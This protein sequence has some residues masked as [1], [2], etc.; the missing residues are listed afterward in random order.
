MIYNRQHCDGLGPTIEERRQKTHLLMLMIIT[1]FMCLELV[2]PAVPLLAELAE[3][4]LAGFARRLC[5]K[6]Y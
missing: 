4:R 5:L 3:E 2:H 1:P 6:Y